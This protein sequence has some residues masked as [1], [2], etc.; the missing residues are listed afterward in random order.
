MRRRNT[1]LPDADRSGGLP[2]SVQ[3]ALPSMK[4]PNSYALEGRKFGRLT[5]IRPTDKR[6]SESV[7]WQCLCCCGK[8]VFTTVEDFLPL[9]AIALTGTNIHLKTLHIG[10]R[11]RIGIGCA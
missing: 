7:I 1:F 2:M 4:P 3:L 9:K 6:S 8:T 5:V 11:E 10:E